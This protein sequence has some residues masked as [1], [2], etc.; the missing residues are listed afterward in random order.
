MMPMHARGAFDVKLTPQSSGDES[1][2]R[3]MIDKQFH[4]DLEATSR[5][6]MLA[7]G[8]ETK[9]SAGYVA[10]EKV[11]GRLHDRD[12]SFILQHTGTM[13]R[14]EGKLKVEVIPD[15]GTGDLKG[16]TGSMAIAISDGNHSYEFDYN[17][18][19]GQEP[20]SGE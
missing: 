6:E 3:L 1:I 11:T 12:G 14:G 18:P 19:S 7:A 13:T 4:G 8:T 20:G 5:G 16:L 17:L 9:G 10:L 2:G 15:S